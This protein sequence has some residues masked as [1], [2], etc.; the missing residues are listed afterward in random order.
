MI[1][2]LVTAFHFR[3]LLYTEYA[4]Q[5]SVPFLPF[6]G[7]GGGLPHMPMSKNTSV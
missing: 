5:I 2:G 1:F 3:I 6:G 4:Q 7:G